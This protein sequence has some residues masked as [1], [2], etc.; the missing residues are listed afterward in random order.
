MP[1][2]EASCICGAVRLQIA[3]A[4]EEVTDCSCT[5]C[6]RYGVLWAYYSPRDVQ[7]P[8]GVTDIFLRNPNRIEFHR[9]KNCGCIT[10]WEAVYKAYDRMAVNARLLAPEVLARARVERF[11]GADSGWRAK[12]T[13]R[14]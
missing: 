6:R 7:R 1:S 5:L 10:H 3:R 14:D 8:I 11:D 2:I 12:A 4:P 13:P 9:C